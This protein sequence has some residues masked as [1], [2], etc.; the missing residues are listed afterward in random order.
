MNGD[1]QAKINPHKST[2]NVSFSD[3]KVK[4]TEKAVDSNSGDKTSFKDLIMNSNDAAFYAREAQKNGSDLEGAKTDAEF[5]KMLSEKFNKENLRKPQNELDKDSFLKLFVTQLQNQDPLN[6]DDSAQMAAQLAQFQGL[7]QMLN[8]NKNLEKMQESDSTTRAVGLIN[9]VGK[10]I[11]LDSGKIRLENGAI[12]QALFRLDGESVNTTL[13]VRDSAGVVVHAS[14]LGLKQT[15]E[16][17][18]EWNGLKN[19]GTKA[20]AGAY[21]ISVLAKDMNGNDLPTKLTTTVKVTGVD[22]QDSG[23]SFYTD[24]GKVRISEISSV[25]ELG[26]LGGKPG[27]DESGKGAQPG[28]V[29]PGTENNVSGEQPPQEQQA[30]SGDKKQ[31]PTTPASQAQPAVAADPNKAAPANAPKAAA[32]APANSSTPTNAN[33]ASPNNRGL[34]MPPGLPPMMEIP[35]PSSFGN[36]KPAS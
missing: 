32:A 1:L 11:K 10:D 27:K 36:Q 34:M 7:E 20:A 21:T 19:D 22:L 29:V 12:S 8:V 16:H 18:I 17:L 13:E 3:A 15:G 2:N 33:A 23:G 9:F 5:A 35:V 24:M 28:A 4:T 31:P 25:G 6:P 26:A 30:S 14:D